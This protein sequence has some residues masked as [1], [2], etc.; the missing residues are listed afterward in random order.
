MTGEKEREGKKTTHRVPA[1]HESNSDPDPSSRERLIP[2]CKAP[3]DIC[4]SD[5]TPSA[6]QSSASELF[7]DNVEYERLPVAEYAQLGKVFRGHPDDK[8]QQMRGLATS[9]LIGGR[10]AELGPQKY[11]PSRFCMA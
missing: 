9:P 5:L 4:S 10:S 6:I 2:N 3:R 7:P 1:D 8:R 11:L